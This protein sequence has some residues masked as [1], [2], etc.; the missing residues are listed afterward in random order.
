MEQRNV[1]KDLLFGVAVG[2]ALGVPV[3]FKSREYLKRNP[4]K[5]FM[6]YGTYNQPAG[7]FSDDSSLTFCLAET[8]IEGFDLLILANKFIDW[9]QLGYWTACGDA[10]DIGNTTREALNILR[11]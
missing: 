1:C 7:T 4:V 11:N 10:F 5:D 3:E 6:G 2:D 8:L 9:V